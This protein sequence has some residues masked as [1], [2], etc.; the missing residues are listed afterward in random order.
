[1]AEK[2]FTQGLYAKKG[3][4]GPE[5]SIQV[6]T[7]I[8]FLEENKKS[9]GYVNIKMGESQNPKDPTK[10]YY[11]E[12]DTWEPV[13]SSNQPAYSKPSNNSQETDNQDDKDELPF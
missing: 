10:P 4:Y 5:I 3:K 8:K 9:S 7:F 13:Q 2:K 12:L 11:F 6:E 1:M